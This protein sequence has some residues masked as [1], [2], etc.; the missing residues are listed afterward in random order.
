MSDH[1][2]GYEAVADAFQRARSP[3]GAGVVAEWAQAFTAPADILDVGCGFGEPVTRV[4]LE[5]GHKV[6]GIDASP[7]L[8]AAFRQNFPDVP[9]ACEPAQTSTFFGQTYDG[10]VAVGLIFLFEADQQTVLLRR[11]AQALRPGGKLLFSAPVEEGSWKD[12]LTQQTSVSL[13]EAAYRAAL[14][15]A[16][17]AHI[18]SR[19]DES[20]NHHYAA[21]LPSA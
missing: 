4:L 1:S 9:V 14:Q 15:S 2:H 20:R 19:T 8:V 12:I 3:A 6:S 11:F 21:S 5:A 13:G 18:E 16:G 10:I 17:F 7:S